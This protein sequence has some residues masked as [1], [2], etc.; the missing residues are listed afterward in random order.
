[1]FCVADRDLGVLVWLR[2]KVNAWYDPIAIALAMG[3]TG[4]ESRRFAPGLLGPDMLGTGY[5]TGSQVEGLAGTLVI[6]R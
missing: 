3:D 1:M 2:N 4:L 5:E 6:G